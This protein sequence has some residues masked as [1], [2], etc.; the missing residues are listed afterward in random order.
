MT[1]DQFSR[2]R[3]IGVV[4]ALS[5]GIIA[6]SCSTV[7]SEDQKAARTLLKKLRATGKYK[8]KKIDVGDNYFS[9][10]QTSIEAGTIVVWTNVGRS[11]HDVVYDNAG[12]TDARTDFTSGV[13]R[14]D[15]I[16]V[17]LFDT[18]GSYPY[19]CS[20]HGGPGRGQWGVLTVT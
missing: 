5:V 4:G 17:V 18:P 11:I 19:H 16:H 15:N 3:F 13:L 9:P 10:K 7:K 1:N 20:Y 14:S 6:S 12:E 8:E 2:R